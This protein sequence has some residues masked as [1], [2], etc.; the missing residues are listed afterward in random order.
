MSEKGSSWAKQ[1]KRFKSSLDLG[2]LP[3]LCP[4]GIHICLVSLLCIRSMFLWFRNIC[5]VCGGSLS[6]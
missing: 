5:L 4:F 3:L 6:E 1:L 2:A